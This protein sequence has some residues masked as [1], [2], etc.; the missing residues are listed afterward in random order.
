MKA[1]NHPMDMTKIR[2]SLE[3]AELQAA[4]AYAKLGNIK[5]YTKLLLLFSKLFY[6]P[7][8]TLKIL[9]WPICIEFEIKTKI[10]LLWKLFSYI[11]LKKYVSLI[12]LLII[13][14]F[15]IQTL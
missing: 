7:Y 9:H 10:G 1:E 8:L 2:E 13:V 5:T 3:L 4:A 14:F 12:H 6:M 11:S 15:F